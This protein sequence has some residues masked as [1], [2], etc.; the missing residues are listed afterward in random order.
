MNMFEIKTK[1]VVG[2]LTGL[3]LTTMISSGQG[4][5]EPRE[6]SRRPSKV[7]DQSS[8]QKEKIGKT[9]SMLAIEAARQKNGPLKAMLFIDQNGA[10]VRCF[11]SLLDEAANSKPPCGLKVERKSEPNSLMVYFGFQVND[12]FVLT[13]PVIAGARFQA[14]TAQ[15]TTVPFAFYPEDSSAILVLSSRPQTALMIFVF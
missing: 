4:Q 8:I 14:E 12:R 5:E 2:V 11:N 1:W 7:N 13:T 6:R 9:Q 10:I 15:P 3:L